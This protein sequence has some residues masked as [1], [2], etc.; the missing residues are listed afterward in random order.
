MSKKALNVKLNRKIPDQD[1]TSGLEI[2]QTERT[3]GEEAEEKQQL[4][5][6]SDKWRNLVDI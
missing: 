1:G 3:T 5:E 2:F 4:W 6:D